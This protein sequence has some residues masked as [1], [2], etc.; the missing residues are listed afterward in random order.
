MKKITFLDL[1]WNQA[2]IRYLKCEKMK[3]MREKLLS[4]C[5]T[6]GGNFSNFDWKYKVIKELKKIKNKK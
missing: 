3:Q 6:Y 1:S 5:I 4:F 2:Q